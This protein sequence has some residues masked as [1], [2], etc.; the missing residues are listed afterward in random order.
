M[1]DPVLWMSCLNVRSG[2]AHKA[3]KK[4]IARG[5]VVPYPPDKPADS[6]RI[7][8]PVVR[9]GP[10]EPSGV[11]RRMLALEA[12]QAQQMKGAAWRRRFSQSL[13]ATWRR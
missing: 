12:L 5:W 8:P 6:I 7:A 2:R 9:Q 11:E 13:T 3:I 1:R 4:C 10:V